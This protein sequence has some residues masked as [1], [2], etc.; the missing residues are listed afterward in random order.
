MKAST[1]EMTVASCGRWLL[2]LACSNFRDNS[3]NHHSYLERP[4]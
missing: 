3:Y 2:H 4:I 1:T